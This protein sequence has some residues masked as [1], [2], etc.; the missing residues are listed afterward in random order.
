MP[1]LHPEFQVHHV[2]EGYSSVV[3]ETLAAENAIVK[4]YRA[5]LENGLTVEM[6]LMGLMAIAWDC[7]TR[8]GMGIRFR[9]GT[10]HWRIIV[11]NGESG[12]LFCVM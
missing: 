10:K 5:D 9:E 6:A 4:S 3:L 2:S 1:G 8:G 12:S 11:I 7:R